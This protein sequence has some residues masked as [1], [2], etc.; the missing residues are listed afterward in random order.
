VSS[1]ILPRPRS[2]PEL[3]DRVRGRMRGLVRGNARD[4]SWV[5]PALIALLV[6]TA[7]AYV[8]DLRS[9]G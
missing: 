3:S 9:S 2:M 7:T 5:R 4:A 6:V 1:T 8:W